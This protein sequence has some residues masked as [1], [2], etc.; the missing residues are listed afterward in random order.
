MSPDSS[1]ITIKCPSCQKANLIKRNDHNGMYAYG[2]VPQPYDCPNCERE[3][4]FENGLWYS[5][6]CTNKQVYNPET[7]T[8]EDLV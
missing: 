1:Q 5:H 8:L 2:F 7:K 4:T 6:C 3:W